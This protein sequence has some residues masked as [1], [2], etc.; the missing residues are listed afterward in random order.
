MSRGIDRFLQ[1]KQR[2]GLFDDPYRFASE[3]EKN[4]RVKREPALETARRAITLLANRNVLPLVS[5]L[6]R[7]AVIGPLANARAAM[8]GPWSAAGAARNCVTILEGLEA[9]LPRADIQFH[10]G[11]SIAGDDIE[12]IARACAVAREA[13]VVILCLGENAGMSGEAACRATPRLPGRQRELAEAV[14]ATGAPVVAVIA[15]GRP[16]AAPWLVERAHA[17]MATWFHGD[18]A[19]A[20]LRMC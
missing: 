2:L 3:G 19:G 14:L 20:R 8:L 1:L 7:V 15:S 18:M 17:T 13:E 5:E 11:V 16:L 4:G 9:V 6:R 12:G 10:E